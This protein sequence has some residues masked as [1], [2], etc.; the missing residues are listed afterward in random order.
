MTEPLTVFLPRDRHDL[1]VYLK[2]MDHVGDENTDN[3]ETAHTPPAYVVESA[4][5]TFEPAAGEKALS[6]ATREDFAIPIARLRRPHQE[7]T[8]DRNFR[9]AR[10]K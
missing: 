5:V 6:A 10:T 4:Q 3:K 1:I 9:P 8:R 7:W 2:Y